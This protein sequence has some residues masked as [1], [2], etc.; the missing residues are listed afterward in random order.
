[1]SAPAAVR[2]LNLDEAAG[3]A[4][5]SKEHVRRACSAGKVRAGKS[6]GV[7]LIDPDS[8]DEWVLGRTSA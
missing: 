5:C 7:W 6:T 8:L 4:R 2:F 3:R 1:M